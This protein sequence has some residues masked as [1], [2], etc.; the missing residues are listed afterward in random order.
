MVCEIGNVVEGDYHLIDHEWHARVAGR[1]P[2]CL[3][4]SWIEREIETD[5]EGWGEGEQN[6]DFKGEPR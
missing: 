1:C 2:L 5:F 6:Q 4:G 3:A